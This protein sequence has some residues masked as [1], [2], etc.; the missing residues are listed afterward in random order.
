MLIKFLKSTDVNSKHYESGD[1][2]NFTEAVADKL[3]ADRK[4]ELTTSASLVA[5]KAKVSPKEAVPA[6]EF[7][8]IPFVAKKKAGK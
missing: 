3:I 5:N 7:T 6:S 4:G 1:V 2:E 8:P